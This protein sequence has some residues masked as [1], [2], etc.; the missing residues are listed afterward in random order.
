[1]IVKLGPYKIQKDLWLRIQQLPGNNDEQRVLGSLRFACDCFE[2]KA[3]K[4]AMHEKRIA[5]LVEQERAAVAAS[6]VTPHVGSELNAE[7]IAEIENHCA[8]IHSGPSCLAT[9]D[10][11]TTEAAP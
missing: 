9:A 5:E 2:E 6:V 10:T 1:V 3:M 11:S 7:I 4:A 8:G